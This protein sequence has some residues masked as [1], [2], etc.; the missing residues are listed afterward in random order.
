VTQPAIDR[1][2]N[3][4]NSRREFLKKSTTA[5]ATA[6]AVG[7]LATPK[8]S[9]AKSAYAGGS[10]T[11]KIGLVGCGGRGAGA[12]IQAMNT[13]S[14]NVELVAV[15]DVFA[16]RLK[17]TVEQ[18]TTEHAEKVRVNEDTSYL[19]LDAYKSVMD[20]DADLVILATPPGFRPVH[21]AAAI[22]AGKHVFMEK[23][24]AVD[25]P[26]IRKVLKYGEMAS[27][28]NL[29]VQ[30]GLQRRH[31]RA[32]RE[33][34]EEL[35]NGIIGD[36][37]FS[38]VYWNS[39]GVWER[40][41]K[42]GDSEL[43]YQMR[44]WYYFNWLCGDHIVEQHIH[45]LDVINW[46][47]D[48]YPKTAQGQGGRLLRNGVDHGQIFDHHFV[49]YTYANGHKMFSQSRHMPQCSKNVSEHVVGSKGYAN[50]SAGRIFSPDGNEIFK[51]NEGPGQRLGHQQEHHDLFASLSQGVMPNEAEYGAKSTM[52]AILGRLATYSGVEL[53]W[54]SAINSNVTLA[55]NLEELENLESEA[56]LQPDENG[57]YP[58]ARPGIGVNQIVDW[59][60]KKA[61]RKRKKNKKG[62][63][64]EKAPKQKMKKEL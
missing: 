13:T 8:L 37:L 4:N 59:E 1:N 42:P 46:L 14:G 39:N 25:A 17:S 38:R 57:K 20:S 26:G 29:L 55:E 3:D 12:A 48:D 62:Q 56:P 21:F 22:E 54:N 32:Y 31:E 58:V 40:P 53:D 45:N 23:P 64:K 47:M 35:Q 15:A 52:T 24:V 6:A 16:D 5:A 28:K 44:N 30:V 9:L 18:A 2:L 7:A 19:G 10:D 61:R 11:V 50:I 33:T 27:E 41:R 43:T 63:Q 36:L 60:I 49:E 51:C 34:I